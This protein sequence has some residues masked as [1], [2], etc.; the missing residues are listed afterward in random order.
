MAEFIDNSPIRSAWIGEQ[1]GYTEQSWWQ[2]RQGN[3]RLPDEKVEL[4]AMLMDETIRKIQ[5][6]ADASYKGEG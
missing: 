3:R 4:L 6:L 2:V 1:L 5:G